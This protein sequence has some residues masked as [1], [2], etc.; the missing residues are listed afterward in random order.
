[1][2]DK[3]REGSFWGSRVRETVA[4][5]V[6]AIRHWQVYQCS[7]EDSPVY[8]EATWFIDPPY[9]KAGAHY[10][11]GSDGLDYDALATWCRS[12]QG[13]VIVCENDGADWLPF[14]E[15]ASTKTTRAGRRSMEV[16]WKN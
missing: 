11:Y 5:Q 14:Q 2:R 1:M 16:V 8:G 13:Q 7:Y 10:K 6:D 12:R 4:S 9:Q 3:I 15:L